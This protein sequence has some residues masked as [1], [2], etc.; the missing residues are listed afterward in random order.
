MTNYISLYLIVALIFWYL[1]D[2]IAQMDFKFRKTFGLG[3]II[4]ICLGLF[5]PISIAVFSGWFVFVT[6]YN[7]IKYKIK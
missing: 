2:G 6:I 7:W 5:W 3:R 1:F 4:C